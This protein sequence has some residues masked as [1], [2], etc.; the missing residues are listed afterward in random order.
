MKTT[1]RRESILSK[2]EY[3]ITLTSDKEM[4]QMKNLVKEACRKNNLL[5]IDY[6]V[7]K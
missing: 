5:K 6:Q 4:E 2:T 3:A 1:N 7:M